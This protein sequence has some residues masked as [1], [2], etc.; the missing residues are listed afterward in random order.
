VSRVL[1]YRTLGLGD[2]LTAVPAYRAVRRALPRYEVLLA[3]PEPLR[4][5]AALTDAVDTFLA[6]PE[7][8]VPPWPGQPPQLAV[9]LHGRGPQS[10][11][12]I[13]A[14]APARLVTF[15]RQELGIAGPVWR[16]DEHE[17]S[18]WCRLLEQS[19]IPADPGDLH[20]ARPGRVSP[21]PGATVVHPGAAA[22]ARRWPA[23][24]FAT[25]A[26]RLRAAGHDVVVTGLGS[27]RELAEAVARTGGLPEASVLAGRLDL[28]GLAALVSAARLVVCGDTGV[29]HLATAYRTPSVILF[30]PTPPARWGPP[31][32]HGRHRVIWHGDRVGGRAPGDG[33]HPALL[34]VT[35][36][37]VLAEVARLSDGPSVRPLPA[38]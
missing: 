29:A 18:R 4:P 33:A 10:H 16:P 34:A 28:G 35:V 24:R 31:P 36:E 23:D 13:S 17:V 1:L 6:T 8:A 2:F 38:R 20:L 3:A 30:G 21:R 7:L 19:G 37:E 32:H 9:N 27:E 15:G 12:A 14:L 11:A 26:A 22:T 25:L 5:L